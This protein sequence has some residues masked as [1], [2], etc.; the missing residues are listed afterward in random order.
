MTVIDMPEGPVEV[1]PGVSI[2]DAVRNAG[3]TPDS[4]IFL[5]GGRPVPM[6]SVPPEGS[7]VTA[8]RVASGG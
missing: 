5:I 4:F 2:E 8:L 3:Y 6:D 1:L 7:N